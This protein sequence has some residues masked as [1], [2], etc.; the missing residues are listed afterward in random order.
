MIILGGIR[1]ISNN[2]HYIL[3]PFSCTIIHEVWYTVTASGNIVYNGLQ[4]CKLEVFMEVYRSFPNGVYN[5][6]KLESL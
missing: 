2:W 1:G 5:V 4:K 6:C 3:L